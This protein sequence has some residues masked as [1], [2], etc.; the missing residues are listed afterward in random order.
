MTKEPEPL[1]Q[2]IGQLVN[3][4][5]RWTIWALQG[6]IAKRGI[7]G[8]GALM[9]SF[10]HRLVY[11]TNGMPARVT[12]GFY[13][14]G[15]FVDMG[16]GKGVKIS[17]VKGNAEKWRA[18]TTSERKGSRPRMPKKWY[19]KEMYYQYQRAAELLA[20]KYAIEVPARFEYTLSERITMNL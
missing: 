2:E 5:A 16:V 9:R 20:R 12:I 4:W 8:S 19:S 13:Y 11:D 7:K 1:E 10:T 15:K 3:D 18:L 6:Q 17:D 14:Y